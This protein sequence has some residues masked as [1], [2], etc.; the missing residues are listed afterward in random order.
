MTDFMH[1]YQN[2]IPPRSNSIKYHL[3]NEPEE[4]RILILQSYAKMYP[5]IVT[6]LLSKKVTKTVMQPIF[7]DMLMNVQ[8]TPQQTIEFF[9]KSIV[10]Y[11]GTKFGHHLLS[12][13]QSKFKIDCRDGDALIIAAK[14]G[15]EDIVRLLLNLPPE[16]CPRADCQDGLALIEA[17]IQGHINIVIL[18]LNWPCHAPRADCR[19]G[20]ALIGATSSFRYGNESVVR[21]LLSCPDHAP[22]ADIQDGAAL[23]WS[24]GCGNHGIVRLLLEWP[25]NPPRADCQKG[26]ALYAAAD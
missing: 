16:Y 6:L 22:C 26:K 15:H 2:E 1:R 11:G 9:H 12:V 24:A 13:C 7:V 3:C 5:S 10:L 23:F 8:R 4:V 18:L 20:E 25:D 17:S 14:E 21:L 19:N